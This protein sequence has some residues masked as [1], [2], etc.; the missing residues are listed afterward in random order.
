MAK[1]TQYRNLDD[2][3]LVQELAEVKDALF[4]LRFQNATGQLDN[5]A[6]IRTV[7]RQ[8]ARINTY[9]RQREIALAEVHECLGAQ[10]A[11]SEELLARVGL[12]LGRLRRHDGL[13][14]VF[15]PLQLVS[16]P[17]RFFGL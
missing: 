14:S 16:E 12:E 17:R 9:I 5:N 13:G 1:D 3:A 7:R 11:E 10:R 15:E 4:K 2:T 6:E 8:I